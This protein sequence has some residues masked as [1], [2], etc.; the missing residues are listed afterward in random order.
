MRQARAPRLIGGVICLIG[1]VLLIMV[2][3]R[4]AAVR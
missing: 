2:P 1:G 4:R 3:L